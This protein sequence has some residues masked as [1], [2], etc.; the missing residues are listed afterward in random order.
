M[1]VDVVANDTDPDGDDLSVTGVFAPLNGTAEVN[2]DGTVTYTPTTGFT[3]ED[4]FVYT[5]EDGF[6]GS[7]EG[8]VTVTV[9]DPGVGEDAD[10]FLSRITAPRQL[11]L[12]YDEE[13]ELRIRVLGDGDTIEQEAT[14][15]LTATVDGDGVEVDEIEPESRTETVKP[16]GA[17]TRFD[18]KAKVECEET[19]R[20]EITW[21]ATIDA[22]QNADATND[23]VQAVTR[24]ECRSKGKKGRGGRDD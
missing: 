16:G 23:T 21:T 22:D 14:V 17:D 5:I 19:G 8:T 4:N 10:V 24:V 6:G 3:G 7:A 20:Y 13:E 15:I 2:A 1:T 18:F 12:R 9:I 11:N